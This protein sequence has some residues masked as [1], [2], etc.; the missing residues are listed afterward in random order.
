MAALHGQHGQP[1]LVDVRVGV[2]LTPVFHERQRQGLR[3][4]EPVVGRRQ[5]DVQIVAFGLVADLPEE[6]RHAAGIVRSP[7]PILGEVGGD[8]VVP[9]AG[10]AAVLY[11]QRASAERSARQLD[12]APGV[13]A[14][15]LR[16]DGQRTAQRVEPEERV[17]TGDELQARNR[18]LRQQVPIDHVAERLVDAHTVLEHR[19]A[20]RHADEGRG[21]EA[22]EADVGLIRVALGSVGRDAGRVVLEEPRDVSMSLLAQPLAAEDLHIGGHVLQRR[23]QARQ[24][25]RADDLDLRPLECLGGI[26]SCECGRRRKPRANAQRKEQR[27]HRAHRG[28]SSSL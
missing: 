22:S 3:A 17:G 15:T 4:F 12:G 6:L 28:V 5:A 13:L 2:G 7:A 20:L 26:V 23:A 25:R 16:V 10:L 11:L 14:P 21:R 9:G 27:A 1:V 19:Q 8:V 24:R 18:R